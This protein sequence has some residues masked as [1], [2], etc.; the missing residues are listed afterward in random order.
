MKVL[1]FGWE[2]PPHISGGLGTA[3]YGMTKALSGFKNVEVIFVVPRKF[4]DEDES[5]LTL[6]GA[7]EV[8]VVRK[9]VKFDDAASKVEYY[10][11]NSG[12][13]PYLGTNEFYE[14]KSKV[15]SGEKRLVETTQEGKIIFEGD[16]GQTLFQEINHYAIVAET[17]A[18][19]LEFDV[20]HAHDWM[21]FPAGMAAKRI[22]G[23]PLV[24]HIH[25]TEFDRSGQHVNP[26]ICTIE[27]DGLEA[28]DRIIAVSNLTRN[29]IIRNYNIEA[30][31]VITVYNAVE[32]TADMERS[33]LKK[34]AK[35]KVVT[36]LGRITMQKGPEYF[37]EAASLALQKMK[38][39]R[40][41][42]AGKG[43]L[44]DAM[45]RRAAELNI[46]D[47]IEFPGFLQDSEVSEL[48]QRSDVFVM[49]SVSEPFGIVTLEA[50]QAGVPV[51][52]SK[53]SGVSEIL[54]NAIKIDYWDVQ[55]MAGAIYE[56]LNDQALSKKLRNQGKKEADHLIWKNSA[57]EV[58]KIYLDLLEVYNSL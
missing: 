33:N 2:F 42:M 5:N 14:L 1:M 30:E 56:L 58:R 47:D 19:E 16:Y 15:S 26:A 55:E 36:F 6:L 27:K 34:N 51:I 25:S 49:P 7:D 28:A 37:V 9:Q 41:V 53:Q 52:I 38:N 46:S 10:E 22:S 35:E 11:L 29:I 39:I 17:I 57:A 21:T 40:F 24:V 4:G 20:I 3:C 48:F 18:R 13:I 50:M 23:K 8:P 31:K 12:L 44:R 54:N 32:L 43:D 45:I